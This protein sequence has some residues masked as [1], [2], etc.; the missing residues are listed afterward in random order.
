MVKYTPLTE[1]IMHRKLTIQMFTSTNIS[2][3]YSQIHCNYPD[4]F[5]G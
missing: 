3:G 1:T 2:T 5:S 4:W